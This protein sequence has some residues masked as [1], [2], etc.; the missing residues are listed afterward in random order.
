M[1]QGSHD[2]S[3]RRNR[4]TVGGIVVFPPSL[5]W[6]GRSGPVL[7][8]LCPLSMGRG[9]TGTQDSKRSTQ[10]P[11]GERRYYFSEAAAPME[12]RVSTIRRLPSPLIVIWDVLGAGQVRSTDMREAVKPIGTSLARRSDGGVTIPP[13]VSGYCRKGLSS[14][15]RWEQRGAG[16]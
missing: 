14:R 6:A 16:R 3:G 8:R 9:R 11:I 12:I 7:A 4:D 2:G 10:D 1:G 15:R 13:G 5:M